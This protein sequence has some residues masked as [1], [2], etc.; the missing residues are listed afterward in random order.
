MPTDERHLIAERATLVSFLLEYGRYV[1]RRWWSFVVG[2]AGGILFVISLVAPL[3]LPVWVG[4]V[5]LFGG[6]TVA[7]SFA[8]KDMRDERAAAQQELSEARKDPGELLRNCYVEGQKLHERIVL[9]QSVADET[10]L[11]DVEDKSRTDVYA[12]T[13]ASWEVLREHFPGEEQEFMGPERTVVVKAIGIFDL[14]CEQ[15][16]QQR[17]GNS[18]D[19]FL[20]DKLAFLASIA[21]Q[22]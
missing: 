18:V 5:I 22:R 21:R 15:A 1:A 16:T 10:R 6:L 19:R 4:L 3:S 12:W 13:K 9:R 14:Y 11:Q 8:F 17:Y 20:E 7:Q 2:L